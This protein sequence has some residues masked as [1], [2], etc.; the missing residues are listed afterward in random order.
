MLTDFTVLVFC[1]SGGLHQLV[2]G[3]FLLK[4]RIKDGGVFQR[5]HGNSAIELCDGLGDILKVFAL[6]PVG[7][8]IGLFALLQFGSNDDNVRVKG[9]HFGKGVE[10]C[11]DGFDF[12]VNRDKHHVG[13]RNGGGNTLRVR[14]NRPRQIENNV[15]IVT[16]GWK[17]LIEV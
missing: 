13:L 6:C 3:F 2:D 5:K 12:V 11:F 7:E 14:G 4:N 16:D 10:S 8:N 1:Q 15:Y 9:L 17:W